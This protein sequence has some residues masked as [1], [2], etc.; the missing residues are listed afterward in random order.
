MMQSAYGRGVS[1]R[2]GFLVQSH[3]SE[4]Y[5]QQFKTISSSY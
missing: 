5:L 3:T 1:P 4:L 2:R